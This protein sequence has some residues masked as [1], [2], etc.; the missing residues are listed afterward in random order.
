MDKT[1]K[2]ISGPYIR[3][4]R[5]RKGWTQKELSVRMRE[6]G[7]N[8]P[9]A[10]I[11]RIELQTRQVYDKELDAFVKVLGVSYEKLLGIKEYLKAEEMNEILVKAQE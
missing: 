2:N 8:L 3:A 5:E 9:E 11:G 1:I 10:T 6:F 4:E 7:V